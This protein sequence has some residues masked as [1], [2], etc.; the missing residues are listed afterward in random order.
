V[1]AVNGVLDPDWVEEFKTHY[2]GHRQNHRLGLSSGFGDLEI[3]PHARGPAAESANGLSEPELDNVLDNY[4]TTGGAVFM[5][6]IADTMINPETNALVAEFV[7]KK[8]RETVQDPATAEILCPST[9]PIGTKRIC[10]DTGY[11]ETYNRDNVSLVD[12]AKDPIESIGPTGLRTQ[13]G[14]YEFDT[15]VLATGFDAMTGALRRMDIRGVDGQTLTD[16][17]QKGPRSY[18]G[19]GLAGF[20]N[21]FTITGPG[22]PSVL[23]NMLVSIEQHVDWMVDCIDHMNKSGFTQFEPDL[24]AEDRWVEH[25]NEIANATLFPQGGSWYLG[26]NVPGKPRVFMPYAAGVGAYREICDQVLANNYEGF[27]F[28]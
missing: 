15:L 17:W 22:S 12:V 18:L 4:W 3:V 20:P 6:A 10:V 11:Y 24:D 28:S 25:V 1:P 8:I 5:G 14:E 7:R 27:V 26:A 13:A 9:H 16:K 19:M 21:L 2:Q 23:S